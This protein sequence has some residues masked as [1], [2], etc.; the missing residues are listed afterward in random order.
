MVSGF[1][2]IVS[3]FHASQHGMAILRCFFKCSLYLE[4]CVLLLGVAFVV[5]ERSYRGLSRVS[6]GRGRE[7]NGLLLSGVAAED[8]CEQK[9]TSRLTYVCGS[10]SCKA[11]D[12][13]QH[14]SIS[15]SPKV[16]VPKP[17]VPQRHCLPDQTEAACL[18]PLTL[19]PV[20]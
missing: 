4:R 20:N 11:K 6:E 7:T 12:E 16:F 13:N 17:L 19:Q 5:H 15:P 9:F 14:P 8:K 18:L 3:H 10:I 2:E 1:C